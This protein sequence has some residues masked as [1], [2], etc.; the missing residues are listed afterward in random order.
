E[1]LAVA[2][3]IAPGEG[4]AGSL[5]LGL[6]DPEGR[7]VYIGRAGPGRIA[8]AEW[9]RL[10]RE[11]AALAVPASPLAAEPL[12]RDGGTVRGVTWLR[13]GLA[14][15]VRFQEWTPRGTMRHPVILA[16]ADAPP[17]ACTTA[18]AAGPAR[19]ASSIST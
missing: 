19:F 15:R 17:G 1:L 2:G 14:V 16:V 8:A 9:R 6:F 12:R 7:L 4:G 11:A 18:Q 13:P 5:L 10:L 3:G